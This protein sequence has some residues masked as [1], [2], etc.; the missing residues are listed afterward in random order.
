[1]SVGGCVEDVGLGEPEVRSSS[2]AGRSCYSLHGSIDLSSSVGLSAPGRLP[3]G[4]MSGGVRSSER[5]T[6]KWA[7][8][9]SSRL[10]WSHSNG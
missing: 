7:L 3:N 9:P 2:R 4:S 5:L 1:M 8:R 10:G 6:D